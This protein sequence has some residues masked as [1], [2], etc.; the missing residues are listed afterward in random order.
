MELNNDI[1]L[2]FIELYKNKPMSW[3]L[4]NSKYYNKFAKNDAGEESVAEMKTTADEC[5]NKITS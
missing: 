4:K 2:H 3:N 1:V 5:R